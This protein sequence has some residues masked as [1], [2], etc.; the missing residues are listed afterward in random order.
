[1]KESR[2]KVNIGTEALIR[3]TEETRNKLVADVTKKVSEALLFALNNSVT[4]LTFYWGSIKRDGQDNMIVTIKSEFE[5]PT[6]I[7]LG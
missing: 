2:L 3:M 7:K 4:G 1:M 6:G 5:T